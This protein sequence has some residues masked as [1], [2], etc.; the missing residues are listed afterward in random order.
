VGNVRLAT[1]AGQTIFALPLPA[2]V[3]VDGQLRIAG[4]AT[5]LTSN[6]GFELG[7][8]SHDT[9][10]TTIEVAGQ[11]SSLRLTW[12][13]T[14]AETQSLREVLEVE[15]HQTI[16]LGREL[17]RHEAVLVLGRPRG[18]I[19]RLQIRLP[20]G[21]H[22]VAPAD[23][24]AYRVLSSE[25]DDV[26]EIAPLTEAGSQW[27]V[28]LTAEQP[29]IAGE[30]G[31]SCVLGGFEV[32]GAVR[33]TG[34][35]DV[36][37]DNR[38]RAYYD[39]AENLWQV[40][41]ATS[42]DPGEEAIDAQFQYTRF[43]W[44]LAAESIPQQRRVTV[45]PIYRLDVSAGESQLALDLD[46][47]LSGAQTFSL[48]VD[49]RG[50][51]LTENPIE[52]G[53]IVDANRYIVTSSGRG[54][55]V[56]PLTNPDARRVR[57]TLHATRESQLGPNEWPLPEPLAAFVERGELHV[58]TESALKLVPTERAQSGLAVAASEPGP[59]G[60]ESVGSP[61]AALDFQ[62][63]LPRASLVG[64]L[65]L[66][67]Q[68]V[69]VAPSAVITLQE[70]KLHVVQRLAFE[71]KHQRLERIELV[72]PKGF[73]G[74]ESLAVRWNGAP[75]TVTPAAAPGG[76]T[77]ADDPLALV[78]NDPAIESATVELPRRTL[79][80]FELQLEY[81]TPL[82][83]LATVSAL[84][85]E[86]PLAR[87][88][89]GDTTVGRAEVHWSE[90]LRVVFDAAGA[91]DGWST[92]GD[93]AAA[94]SGLLELDWQSPALQ[95]PLVVDLHQQGGPQL[96]TLETAWIQ[97]WIAGDVRQDRAVYRFHTSFPYAVLHLGEALAETELEVRLDGQVVPFV[98][99]ASERLS[100][101]LGDASE[102]IS[103]T[104]ELRYQTPARLPHW[105]AL[106]TNYPRL[107][108]RTGSAPVYWQVILPRAMHVA[109][110]PA[111]LGGDYWLG[112]KDYRWGRQPTLGQIDLERMT[113]ALPG[114]TPPASVNQYLFR[115]FQLAD[116]LRVVV[117]GQA[118]LVL[119]SSLAAFGLGLIWIRTS[120][121]S[122]P[123]FWLVV[124]LVLLALVFARPEV[125]LLVAQAILWGGIMTLGAEILRKVF[126]GSGL[127]GRGG[128]PTSSYI[129]ASTA[130]TESWNA[131]TGESP[132]AERFAG[133]TT[134]QS[135]GPLS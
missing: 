17:A 122:R 78:E 70:N 34:M 50:W 131:A 30:D 22:L 103:H 33:Q 91:E 21:S 51:Q 117:I 49:L 90:P 120:L 13:A 105:G 124:S 76:E 66:R 45:K 71:V 48:R 59:P 15:T 77:A 31:T 108:C 129:P 43:P 80:T 26:V 79:G 125:S 135:G 39:A 60:G 96:A 119:V 75:I 64:E 12:Q 93:A 24:A 82:A 121:A 99:L 44:Q 133:S 54:M 118:W 128:P 95:L 38:L 6:P 123:M 23:S 25:S 58:R 19:E 116:P 11:G 92:V 7:E 41:A 100:V 98:R 68:Q 132:S 87:S 102:T 113:S 47:R 72:A 5:R 10:R 35:V 115:G 40:A 8:T 83:N 86:L 81:E 55:L 130:A 134:L 28:R 53:G 36:V 94:S 97:S 114:V 2:A 27:T 126:G 112:W 18:S 42:A 85:L 32:L 109:T 89:S 29:L 57:L 104:L 63:V 107:E 84:P 37:V 16:R 4:M 1:E 106:E 127:P 61:E 101:Q 69:T 73:W 14:I 52:S 46:Y 74:N 20:T 88:L 67:E 56:L 9:E 111:G 110:E 65:S 62:T 3:R